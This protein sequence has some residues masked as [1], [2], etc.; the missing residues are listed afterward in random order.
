VRHTPA[1]R[2]L[3]GNS[4]I[5]T[6][7]LRASCTTLEPGCE[8]EKAFRNTRSFSCHCQAL[9]RIVFMSL[10]GVPSPA[11]SLPDS[12][13]RPDWA[14][15]PPCS[16]RQYND[17]VRP[18]AAHATGQ[19]SIIAQVAVLKGSPL[20]QIVKAGGQVVILYARQPDFA[21]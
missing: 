8:R 16:G 15:L 4:T 10:C 7:A 14:D 6:R 17:A 2:A 1:L 12:P 18:V 5:H 13:Q 21:V 19:R 20:R 9:A 11:M 3:L